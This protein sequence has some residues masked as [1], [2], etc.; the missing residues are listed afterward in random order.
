MSAM[1]LSRDDFGQCDASLI[2][3]ALFCGIAGIFPVDF[4][5]AAVSGACTGISP[6]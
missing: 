3:L 4:G 1:V 2:S 5:P 6:G